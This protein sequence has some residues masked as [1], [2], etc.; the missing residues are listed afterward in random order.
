MLP[1]YVQKELLQKFKKNKTR[2]WNGAFIKGYYF[3]SQVL[4]YSKHKKYILKDITFKDK[5]NQKAN[6]LFK[7]TLYEIFGNFIY[8]DDGEMEIVPGLKTMA[9]SLKHMGQKSDIKGIFGELIA[10]YYFKKAYNMTILRLEQ[11]VDTIEGSEGEIDIIALDKQ[12]IMWDIE[13]KNWKINTMA[14]C[15]TL[16]YK[17]QKQLNNSARNELLEEFKIM[18]EEALGIKIPEIRKKGILVSDSIY[19]SYI[20]E[21]HDDQAIEFEIADLVPDWLTKGLYDPAN[22]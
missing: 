14:S 4:E 19:N 9:S 1:F 8:L 2:I 6:V 17:V 13:V 11:R 16:V 20:I 18:H 12:N 21:V 5:Q 7:E 10:A 22:T 15:R 3:L